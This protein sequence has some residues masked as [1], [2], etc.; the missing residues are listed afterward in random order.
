MI[1]HSGV[2]S[3]SRSPFT[4]AIV[5]SVLTIRWSGP[6]LISFGE[7]GMPGTSFFMRLCSGGHFFRCATAP[8]RTT[9]RERIEA[10]RHPR[11]HT[12]LHERA[13]GHG[14][15]ST[16]KQ[17]GDHSHR[18]FGV[19]GLD[20]P[21]EAI[22]DAGNHF[23]HLHTLVVIQ[24]RHERHAAVAGADSDHRCAATRQRNSVRR[25]RARP[26]ARETGRG[27]EG[28]GASRE[29]TAAGHTIDLDVHL[30]AAV[31][32]PRSVI[33]PLGGDAVGVGPARKTGRVKVETTTASCNTEPQR[34]TGGQHK[35]RAAAERR[36]CCRRCR[37]DP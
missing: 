34:Q 37:T 27:G 8:S 18:G 14:Q 2:I 13:P 23:F 11:G 3:V 22:R 15:E 12:Q 17:T 24:Q 30:V 28:G 35:R 1:A 25:T 36:A 10:T 16:L 21:V 26:S 4:Q 20:E 32:I 31:H 33:S 5:A 29:T 7:K 6:R 19:G 9:A